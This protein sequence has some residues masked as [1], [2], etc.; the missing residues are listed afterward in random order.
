[1]PTR[2]E[3]LKSSALGVLSLSLGKWALADGSKK[4]NILL[5]LADDLSWCDAGCTGNPDVRTPH[6]DGLA[7]EGM[8]F[9]HAFTATAMCAPSRQ[10]LYTGVFPVRNGAYPNHSKVKP[11]TRS[12]VHHLGALGY[13]VGLKG[14]RHVGPRRS[15]P[16]EE[17][18]SA[19]DFVRDETRPFCLLVASDHPHLDWPPPQGYAP[20]KVK[21]PP[22]LV[23]NPETRR[24]LCSYYTEVTQFDD[25]VGSLLKGLKAAGRDRDTLVIAT[26]E[27]GSAFPGGKW[28]CYDYGLRTQFI[29][30]WP[31]VVKPGSKTD[32]L[33]QYVD[34]VPTLV[35]L[36]GGD[37]GAADTGLPGDPKGG[38]GFDGRSFLN[39]LLGKAD[40]HHEFVYGVHTTR[41]I[42][43]GQPYP[44]R[45]I[46][47]R[48]TKYIW[49]L[50]PDAR[51][52]NNITERN[53]G[54]F[55]RSW[56]RDAQTNPKAAKLVKRFQHRP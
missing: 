48:R 41:G 16:F 9:T 47:D 42:L 10:Q 32:A 2:R 50:M 55:W 27:Q 49:N 25:E 17:V 7:K 46:R 39:V 18:R 43:F 31:G 14:K 8:L 26:S 6:L 21:V 54:G 12:L 24:A 36:A 33:I 44:V 34:V 29:V 53:K 40:V 19:T 52:R 22:H 3:F 28:T 56:V 20:D 30:R 38:T 45:S 5:V 37:P 35:E 11:G 13:R 1:M 15:F 4:P 51:F 23:D